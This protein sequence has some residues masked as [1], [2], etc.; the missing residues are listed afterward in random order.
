M[1]DVPIEVQKEILLREKLD[2]QEEKILKMIEERTKKYITPLEE[3]LKP[4][5]EEQVQS[6][7]RETKAWQN[8]RKK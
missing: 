5:W 2:K 1:K 3:R 6:I 4:I 8:E 7:L